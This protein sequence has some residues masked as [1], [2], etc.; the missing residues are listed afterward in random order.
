MHLPDKQPC[1]VYLVPLPPFPSLIAQ[2]LILWET[3]LIT[4]YH[5]EPTSQGLVFTLFCHA[6]ALHLAIWGML[7][8]S[9]V[10]RSG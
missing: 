7:G 8:C 4:F 10:A 6:G 2:K 9:G 3:S 1:P 5:I